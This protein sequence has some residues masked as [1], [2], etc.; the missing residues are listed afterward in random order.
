MVIIGVERGG[1]KYYARNISDMKS[2]KKDQNAHHHHGGTTLSS[3][4]TV[5]QSL[6]LG[7]D[8]RN[9]IMN[10]YNISRM[11]VYKLTNITKLLHFFSLGDSHKECVRDS[12][13]RATFYLCY[14]QQKN[15][16]LRAQ[17]RNQH[18]KKI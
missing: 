1:V 17:T 16:R 2:L 9:F 15:Y 8:V 3:R 10:P 18:S 13:K 11:E 7:I 4:G 14:F 6:T 5:P 12:C